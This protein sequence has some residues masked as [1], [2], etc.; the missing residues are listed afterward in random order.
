MAL[1]QVEDSYNSRRIN[2]EFEKKEHGALKELAGRILK[3]S[4]T[5]MRSFSELLRGEYLNRD[6]TDVFA[7]SLIDVAEQILARKD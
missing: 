7:E 2:P 4:Y 6:G 3:L 5:D 1:K